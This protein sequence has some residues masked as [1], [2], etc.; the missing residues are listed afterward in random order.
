MFGLSCGIFGGSGGTYAIVCTSAFAQPHRGGGVAGPGPRCWSTLTACP[1]ALMRMA[2]KAAGLLAAAGG[3]VSCAERDTGFGT[4]AGDT[5]DRGGVA[6]CAPPLFAAERGVVP[7]RTLAPP[8]LPMGVPGKSMAS[9]AS[10]TSVT[11]DLAAP[12]D[13]PPLPPTDAVA[14]FELRVVLSSSISTAT[15]AGEGCDCARASLLLALSPPPPPFPLS[16]MRTM[17][18]DGS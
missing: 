15:S 1:P 3:V 16:T 5:G 17:A 9:S 4:M 8:V 10:S 12:C 6:G 2:P 14:V 7:R 18:G 11:V 13:D